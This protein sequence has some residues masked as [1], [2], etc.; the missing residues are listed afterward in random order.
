MRQ[1]NIKK[2]TG[3][4]V[5]DP[6]QPIVIRDHRGI[7]FYS[8]EPMLP[9]VKQFNLP[10]GTYCVDTGYFSPMAF[11]VKY[12]RIR[13][14]FPERILPKPEFFAVSFGNNPN[15]CT[16]FWN[17]KRIL[18]DNQFREKPLYEVFSIL[19]HEEG[20]HLYK[21]EK[22]ADIYAANKMLEYG[23]NPYY[24]GIAPL[25]SLSNKQIERKNY[26]VDKLERYVL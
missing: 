12:D 2:K 13:L 1:I 14:P 6:F 3:F 16:I 26:V 9:K 20:H 5:T 25:A 8:T 11:P 21:T 24:T 23:F 15:K 7:F 4:R 10:P 17:E 22:Y 19:F 18:F